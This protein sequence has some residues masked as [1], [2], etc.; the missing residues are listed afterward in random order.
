MLQFI[1]DVRLKTADTNSFLKAL[2][3]RCVKVG[4][5]HKVVIEY[6][7]FN[8]DKPYVAL[9]PCEMTLDWGMDSALNMDVDST[10][11]IILDEVI[12][13]S[14]TCGCEVLLIGR[15]KVVGTPLSTLLLKHTNCQLTIVNS[16]CG[17]T[18]LI[19]KMQRADVIINAST[20]RIMTGI[21][22]SD[23]LIIDVNDNLYFKV[24]H[25]S[26][27]LDQRYIGKATVDKILNTYE[28]CNSGGDIN[29]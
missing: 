29:E 6:S 24:D 15:G 8:L 13:Y 4:V 25:T 17:I 19:D 14:P 11:K 5:P 7:D 1:V 10:A 3:S 12:N 28:T 21:K 23:K 2:T 27:R 16:W 22:L 26:R 9:E 20:S 18:S